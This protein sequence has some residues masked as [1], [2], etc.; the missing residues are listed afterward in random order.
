MNQLIEYLICW[1]E[2]CEVK[3]YEEKRKFFICLFMEGQLRVEFI[4]ASP[5]VVENLG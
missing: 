1:G 5:G 3:G 4:E 2:A